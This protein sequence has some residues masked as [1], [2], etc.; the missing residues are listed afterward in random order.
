MLKIS[1]LLV[2][3][4]QN[5]R[6]PNFKNDLTPVQLEPGLNALPHN[7]AGMAEAVDF[8]RELQL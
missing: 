5:H 3:G 7:S 1:G 6:S 8:F 2:E 4:L